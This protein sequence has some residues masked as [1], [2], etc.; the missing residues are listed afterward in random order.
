M[1]HS[2][3]VDPQS[4]P[5]L[6]IVGE[7]RPL[8]DEMLGAVRKVFESGRFLYGPAVTELENAVA[9]L[10]GAKHAI[11]CASGSDA[12]LLALMALDIGAGDEVILPSFTFFATASAVERLGAKIVFVDIDPLSFNL[13]LAKVQAA[14]TPRTKAVIPVHL[15]GR[16]A[17]MTELQQI[18][19]AAGIRVVEDAAQAIGSK[20]R[21]RGA[22]AWGDVGCFSFY[23]T[24]NL[25][26][27]GD[28]GMLTTSNDE[29]AE[30]LRLFAAHGMSPRY[31]HRVIGI[32]SRLDTLQ[33]AALCVKLKHLGRWTE[34]RRQNAARYAELFA[35]AGLADFVTLP[36]D[37]TDGTHVW[38]Q[39][40]IRVPN[41]H[42]DD[43]RSHLAKQRIA[44]E[45]YY[46]I[47]LHKQD[48]FG[49]IE[50]AA[51]SL[52]ETERAAA[53]VLSLPIF[54]GLTVG[55]QQRVVI[56]I[57]GYFAGRRI[58]AA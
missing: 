3:A 21:N 19:D 10:S 13:D 23:P 53:E 32:N 24:K 4:V 39:F 20:H 58:N 48:C 42:R 40:T 1:S 44:S 31:V 45:I 36:V 11:G 8:H 12:L 37:D 6:D 49:H 28:G 33:A 14:I 15:F 56:G 35:N 43:L 26:G 47:P 22:G 2:R 5:L 51:G 54:P 16:M 7:N 25:G 29:L 27:C 55:E 18:A 41:S 50:C 30:R 57:A 46:P 38:N 52:L 17:N 9:R 34:S